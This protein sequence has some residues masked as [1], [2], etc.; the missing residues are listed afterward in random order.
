MNRRYA[1]IPFVIL[2]LSS[3]WG[4]GRNR[5]KTQLAPTQKEVTPPLRDVKITQGL[6]VQPLSSTTVLIHWSTNAVTVG[7]LR[8][9]TRADR[10]DQ[11][12]TEPWEGIT[13]RVILKNL[14]PNTTYYYRVV[15]SSPQST[16][17]MS[18]AT[19]FRTTS[20]KKTR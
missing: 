8:Y 11:I 14:T 2:L 18:S 12:A 6:V 20:D 19:T 4:C 7:L 15:T 10:L 3:A 13:H 5:E 16:E 9:G 1:F 17:V